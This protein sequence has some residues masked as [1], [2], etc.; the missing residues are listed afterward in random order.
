MYGYL[1]KATALAMALCSPSAAL[2][3]GRYDGLEVVSTTSTPDGQVIDWIV[4]ESQGELASPPP[5]P[6]VK[7]DGSRISIEDII[8]HASI[9]QGPNGTVPILRSTLIAPPKR[10]PQPSDDW[11]AAKGNMAQSDHDQIILT[12]ESYFG[13]HWYASSRQNVKNYGGRAV[14]SLFKAYTQS[15]ADF[16]LLQTAIIRTNAAPKGTKY[17]TVEA[18][19]INY[20]NQV[21]A[22]HLFSYFTTNGHTTN[23]DR[24]GG[25]NR[26][27]AG[28]VQVDKSLYP[29][30]PFHP[31]SVNGGAQCEVAIGYYLFKGN[32][33]LYVQDRYIGYYPA[34]M[35]SQGRDAS[36]TLAVYSDAIDYY[37]EVY[38][39][40]S[41]LT[42]T[43]MGSGE[44]P[45]LGFLRAA[46]LHNIAY[47]DG[48]Y[49]SYD[50][51]GSRSMVVS[52]PARYRIKPTWGSGGK[53]GSYFYLGGPG[54]NG[55]VNG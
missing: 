17:Q 43:D 19:W 55:V 34:S 18:G 16:S 24:I 48:N 41:T 28:W 6:P 47:F 33:W 53:W 37:G 40:E 2:V 42:T 15:N 51:D 5:F 26:D 49:Y 50:F 21:A 3:D 1:V 11:A 27:Y 8:F 14:F 13:K 54:A 4:P 52:D 45:E 9:P 7:Q 25:W 36:R 22:P 20:P 32:W 38:N 23:G 39:S 46:Y 31:L 30:M 12:Q 35:F 10:P 44:F 29:G